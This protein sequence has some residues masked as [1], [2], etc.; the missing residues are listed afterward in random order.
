MKA[1]ISIKC[2]VTKEQADAL[3]TLQK[4][5]MNAC[6]SIVPFVIA[7]R[8]WNR[9][10]L[11]KLTYNLIRQ[12]SPLGSQ[13]VRNAIFSV[14][15]A[16]KSKNILK[17][18]AVPTI[19]FRK[20][21]SIHFDKRTYKIRKDGTLSLYTLGKRI[22]VKMDMGDFQR[23]YFEQGIPKEAELVCRKGTWYFN[24]VLEMPD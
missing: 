9:F 6:N 13:M 21:R 22:Q 10:A 4:A 2:K 11:H 16:Y 15:K 3:Q 1:T 24:L 19:L 12:N 5:Y 8:C 14:C 7:N 18:E 23:Q 17:E 20:Y